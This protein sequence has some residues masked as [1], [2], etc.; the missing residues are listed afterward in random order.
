LSASL[1]GS[2]NLFS[3]LTFLFVFGLVGYLLHNSTN[4]GVFLTLFLPVLLGATAAVGVGIVFGRLFSRDVG[5]LTEENSR[6]EGRL[7]RVSMPIRAGGVGEVI[8]ERQGGGRQS[9]GAR[10]FDGDA[11]PT[12]AEIVIVGIRDGIASVQ[13]WDTFV[14]T[15]RAGRAPI[16]E[17]LGPETVQD[18]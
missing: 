5:L 8:F 16:L 11:I 18:G 13:T 15:V 7:G 12:D 1:L 2:L 10:S 14:R 3:V 4:L 9:I 17:A 6:L